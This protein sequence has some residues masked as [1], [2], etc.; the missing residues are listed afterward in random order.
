MKYIYNMNILY[1]VIQMIG[2]YNFLFFDLIFLLYLEILNYEIRCLLGDSFFV[3]IRLVLQV[4]G[5][6]A[7]LFDYIRGGVFVFLFFV[8]GLR[9]LN[10]WLFVD[11]IFIGV[12]G[13][14]FY[15]NL[16]WIMN[17]QVNIEGLSLVIF[18]R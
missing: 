13:F 4:V 10:I 3:L 17:L 15:V 9:D 2:I 16:F 11:F 1:E 12:I 6:M 7:D 14:L 18:K 5:G 8:T